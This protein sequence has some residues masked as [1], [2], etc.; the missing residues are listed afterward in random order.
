MKIDNCYLQNDPS[1]TLGEVPYKQS[2]A[3]VE[4]CR[5]LEN[6]VDQLNDVL[7]TTIIIQNC[8]SEFP[9]EKEKDNPV[10]ESSPSTVINK[11]DN[12]LIK[13]QITLNKLKQATENINNLLN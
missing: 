7:G 4:I 8:L 12:Q 2:P 6:Q 13:F 5:V 10:I 9:G 3:F 11:L 1:C